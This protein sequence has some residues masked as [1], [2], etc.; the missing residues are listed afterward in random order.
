M[1]RLR[2]VIV[3]RWFWPV[4][5]G[6]ERA[7]ANLA[8]ELAAR[9]V[10]VALVTVQW[11]E[12]W[13]DRIDYRGVSVVRLPR[14]GPGFFGMRS[15]L[16][17]LSAYLRDNARHY[18]AAYVCGLRHDC[19]AILKIMHRRGAPVV[20]RPESS[21]RTGDCL[22]QLESGVG[23]RIKRH[24]LKADAFVGPTEI[25]HRELLA[26]GYPRDRIHRIVGGVP[27]PRPVDAEW[28]RAARQSLENVNTLLH[29]PDHQPVAVYTGRLDDPLGPYAAI[30][31]WR[32]VAERWPNARLWLVGAGANQSALNRQIDAA[33]L[34]GRIVIPG[35]F[36]DVSELLAAADVA[37]VDPDRLDSQALLL[38]AMAAG[39]PIAAADRPEHRTVLE[40]Q[41]CTRLFPPGSGEI[42]GRTLLDLFDD[43][44]AAG[45]LG[46]SARACAERHYALGRV[47]DEHLALLENLVRGKRRPH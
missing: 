7:I 2:L 43:V 20:L 46:A 34:V 13:P 15:W 41:S 44:D 9:Q 38:E 4:A 5:G 19:P 40:G 37:I 39:L 26:A 16:R 33:R 27:V 18:D 17:N 32:G 11:E 10:D 3:T 14:T 6:T 12:S 30:A 25:L 22:W 29:C 47:A 35:V 31:A 24:A 8:T 1:S 21:G 28:R 23:R 36:A 45:R 42:L